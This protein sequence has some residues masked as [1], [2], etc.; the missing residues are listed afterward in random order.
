MRLRLQDI[1]N[2]EKGIPIT[3]PL[4]VRLTTQEIKDITLSGNGKLTVSEVKQQDLARLLIAGNGSV[5][6]GRLIA[7][8]FSA[9]IDGNG[10]ID[11]GGG[12]VRDAR[13]T[14][15]GA[16]GFEGAKVATR[17]LRL[18][19]IGNAISTATV[20]EQTEI[21]NDGTGNITIGGKGTCFIKKAGSAAI[22]C[23]KIDTGGKK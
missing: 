7:D 10:K 2:N 15:D 8:Q 23:A 21:F 14:I 17:K 20:A 16:G 9:Q 3:T 6:I 1:I 19:H 11:L 5:T 22:N 18:E 13:V 4:N 12:V